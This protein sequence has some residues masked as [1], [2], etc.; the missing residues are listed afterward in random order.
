M[1]TDI[2]LTVLG[3]G[4]SA[5]SPMIGCDCAT[6]TSNNPKNQRTRCSA[7]LRI[8]C[9]AWQIDTGTDFRIQALR[10]HLP[11]IDGVL[12]TH[13]HADH[14]NGIDD[15]RAFCYRQQAAIPVYGN[16]FTIANIQNR[17]DYAL[18]PA[19]QHWNRPVLTTHVLPLN[20]GQEPVLWIDQVPVWHFGVP[21]GRWTTSAYRIGNIAWFTDLNDIS[22]DII[23]R[24]HGLDY[25]FLDCLMDAAY[26]SHLST[27]QAFDFARCIGAKHTFFLH[28]NHSQEWIGRAHV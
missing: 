18:Y 26:P 13:P 8:G 17:F 22:D 16:H 2:Q 19:N 11:H 9:E 10:E 3:C 28:L 27:A 25:L 5:G 15:L 12:Y 7:Y 23:D 14:L 1:T 4:S 21:H 6:C 24:L 20:Q